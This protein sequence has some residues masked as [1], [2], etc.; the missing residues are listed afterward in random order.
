[1][2]VGLSGTHGTGKTT[3]GREAAEQFGC[4]FIRT[5]VSD[6]YRSLGKDPRVA[7]TFM[8]RMDCQFAILDAL[9][10]QWRSATPN[11]I[12]LTDRTPIDL[13]GYALSAVDSYATLTAAQDERLSSYLALCDMAMRELFD[14]VALLPMGKFQI[15]RDDDKITGHMSFCNRMLLQSLMFGSVGQVITLPQV[16]LTTLNEASIEGRVMELREFIGLT[17][18]PALYE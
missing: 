6:V 18:D 13:V 9:I 17:F 3:L 8:Q 12:T 11:E 5:T 4:A 2:L 15:V 16:Y 10:A 7:M 1:M 14:R